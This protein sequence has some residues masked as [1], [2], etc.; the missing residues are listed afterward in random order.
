MKQLDY[1]SNYVSNTETALYADNFATADGYKKY[2]DPVSFAQY[3]W[4]NELTRNNDAGFWT[5]TFLY[6]DRSSLLNMG[7]VWDFDVAFGNTTYND[8]HL[9]KGW[10][11]KIRCGLPG[12]FRI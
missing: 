1:I 4:I 6:K 8:N 3:F 2:L 11:I 12:Y 10:W 7:P 9:A 5:S